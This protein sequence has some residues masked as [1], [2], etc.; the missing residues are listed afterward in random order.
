MMIEGKQ[1]LAARDKLIIALDVDTKAKALELA[2]ALRDVAGMFKIG[3]QLFTAAGPE[4]VRD[5]IKRGAKIFLDLKFHDIP[6]TVS[7]AGV[8]ATRLGVSIF[9]I[10][11]SGGGEM[12]QR[13]S[14]AV[15]E[16]AGREGFPRPSV[17]AV[18][19]LTS[20]D[21][22]ELNQVGI[23]STPDDQTVRLARLAGDNGM[24]GVVASPQDI[25]RVRHAVTRSDFLI[26]TPGVRPAGVD[27]NDQ[28]RIM[29]PG[30][31]IRAGADYL[32]VGR[33]IL[34]AADPVA[35]AE[36]IIREISE[37]IETQDV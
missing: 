13:T 29:S 32:V 1:A 2:N 7:A 33:P 22:I 28:K 15:S 26:V 25:S 14:D 37:A 36:N 23:A 18:T 24:D 8:E 27:T 21:A 16:C 4:I 19:L 31:A 30:E 6:A 3:S 10:H 34:T 11:A 12:M 17:I 5:V 20:S 35:A 9:N